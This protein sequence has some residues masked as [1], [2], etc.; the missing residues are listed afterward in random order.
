MIYR[1]VVFIKKKYEPLL[2][3]RLN[4]IVD[5]LEIYNVAISD[6]QTA[7]RFAERMRDYKRANILYIKP[8]ED[9]KRLIVIPP[10]YRLRRCSKIR[11]Q[12]TVVERKTKKK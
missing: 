3:V 7:K 5:N 10:G 11:I 8:L 2:K 1:P 4:G 6:K 9:G 12:I